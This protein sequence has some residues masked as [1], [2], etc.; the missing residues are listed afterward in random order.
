MADIY[1]PILPLQLD[2]RNT[3][4]LVR[5]MQTKIFLESGGQLNDFSPASPL[6]ALVEGQAY[7]QNELL[8]Y[9]NSLPEA[10]TLQWLRQLGIQRSV[11]AKAVVEVTFV[12]TEGFN[13]VVTIP[14]GT[15]V[16]TASKLNFILGEDVRI[17][18]LETSGRGLAK[19]EKWG[20]AY[21]VEA[22]TIEKIN[23]NIL[24]LTGVLNL[25]QAQG[26][27]D[28]ESVE[29]MKTKAFSLLR[30]RGLIS[31]EDY[32]NELAL[33]VPEASIIKALSY[34]ERFLVEEAPISGVV[35]ICLGDENGEELT[36]T[37]KT[38]ALKALRK[39]A[40]IGTSISLISPEVTPVETTVTIE[41][42]DTQFSSGI[43]LYASTINQII[44]NEIAPE[45]IELGGELDYQ[46]IF[47][48]I[49]DVSF[50]K[51]IRGLSFNLLKVNTEATDAVI[52]CNPPFISEEINGVCVTSSEAYIDSVNTEFENTNPIRTFRNYKNVIS[53]VAMS[54]QAP[55]TYTFVN[56]DYDASLRG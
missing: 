35:M 26:G 55:L 53:F 12:K 42:D 11:G 52:N 48:S 9:L 24:G 40:P 44:S 6:S 3:S 19:A 4:A 18:N 43:D 41:Y 25:T 22:N 54:T 50:V 13:R 30:R 14:A 51:R 20:S 23:K 47:N 7:A 17:G 32:E 21:N 16:S 36:D 33:L 27:K 2:P 15:I 1:G 10:Y 49:Y 8:Y 56:R 45:V 28:L 29:N 38:Q 39:R 46:K 5:D 34:E 37:L 31:A